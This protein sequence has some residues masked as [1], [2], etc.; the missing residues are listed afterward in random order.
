MEAR[1]AAFEADFPSLIREA[2]KSAV[3]DQLSS[4]FET[5]LPAYFEQFRRELH[6][7]FAGRWEGEGSSHPP[8]FDPLVPPDLA[9][10]QP[11]HGSGTQSHR[12]H[13]HPPWPQR[14]DFPRFTVGDDLIAWI[15]KAEQFFAFYGIPDAHRVH[16]ASFNFE[17]EI[18][19]WFRW[20]DCTHTT[21]TWTEFTRALC[22]EFGPSEFDDSAEALF[23]LRQIGTLRDYI[24]EF[25]RLAIRSPEIS[26]LLLRSCFLGG[27]KK[28]LRYDV[29]LLKPATV[30][31]AISIAVQ[32]DSK[33]TELKLP[34]PR[35]YTSSKPSSTTITPLSHTVPKTSN[36]AIK[37]LTPDEIQRKRERGECWFCND[38]WVHGHK[39]G[40]KQLLMME[41]ADSEVLDGDMGQ[42][43]P[44]LH[45]DPPELKHMEL[46]ECAF[47][48]T[49]EGPTAQTMKVLGQVNGH[50]VKI[51]LDSGSSHNFVDSKLIKQCGWQAQSTPTFEV[52]IADGGRV[53]SS[54][55]CK[56]IALTLAGYQCS[57]DLYS[58]PLGGCDVVLGVQWLSSVSP[59]L[60]DFQLLTM[61]FTKNHHTYK[62]S[63]HYS[64]ASGIQ[65]VSLHQLQKELTNSKL[66][67]FL[68][69]LDKEKLESCELDSVQLQELQHLLNDFEAI[70]AVPTKLPP[71][72]DHDHHIPLL[73]GA[74]PPSIRP[75]HYGL[76]H[77]TE[78]EGSSRAP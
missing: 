74:K 51:L 10:L 7:E 18:L 35:T 3:D 19:H 77:K 60:W 26:P 4:Q 8:P 2:V 62:L 67:L 5:R 15:Y 36:L 32:L 46:S 58:R 29:K 57:T 47:Y 65:E 70:F 9:P 30:H 34:P 28:E 17:G 68:Y 72:R 64:S 43:P 42:D 23:K 75:Y 53:T 33:L 25:R 76:L 11:P 56:A 54:G 39:C 44:E 21:P 22:R 50:T 38:K 24:A 6:H 71:Q 48:G 27:L 16:T 1:F 12:S 63:H 31:E 14:L 61:E 41:L 49:H 66:G 20:M 78:I 55:C 40:L 37:K 69:S 45:H 59:V 13:W 52:M 73:H